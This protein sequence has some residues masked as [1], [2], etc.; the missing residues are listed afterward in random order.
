MLFIDLEK[1]IFIQVWTH[2]HA[3]SQIHPPPLDSNPKKSFWVN[4]GDVATKSALEL[5]LTTKIFPKVQ[6]SIIYLHFYVALSTNG[7]TLA[8]SHRDVL[9]YETN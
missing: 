8:R 3:L 2:L 4:G 5:T 1:Y 6:G 7:L 9:F